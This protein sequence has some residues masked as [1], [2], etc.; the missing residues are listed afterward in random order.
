ML[1]NFLLGVVD[2]VRSTN[3]QPKVKF[4]FLAGALMAIAISLTPL[5]NAQ[6]ASAASP[7]LYVANTGSDT[8][9]NGQ[10]DNA[11]GSAPNCAFAT[12]QKAVD[13]ASPGDTIQVDAG[14]YHESPNL[15]KAVTLLGAQAG[16]TG[17][18][19]AG[20][21]TIITGTPSISVSNVTVNG[22]EFTNSGV[23]LNVSPGP[24]LHGITVRDSVFT[25][26]D[27][28][29]I[30]TYNA[31][32]IVV[33]QNLFTNPS[34]SAEPMQIKSDGGGGC[35]GTQVL[36]N[37]FNQATTNGSADVNLSCTD[38]NSTNVTVSN[39]YSLGVVNGNFA[40]FVAFSGVT[41]GITVMS[42]TA[43]SEG[44][45]V[46]FFGSVSGSALVTGNVMSHIADSAAVSI[47][48]A[49]DSGTDDTAN[50]GT[51]NITNNDFSNNDKGVSVSTGAL[52]GSAQ[53]IAN[54]NDL[55]GDTDGVGNNTGFD[56]DATQNWWGTA[57]N[58]TIASMI[59]GSGSAHVDYTPY[60]VDSS[61]TTLSNVAPANVYISGSY[62]DGHAGGHAYGYDAFQTI[63]EG[64]D[65]VATGGT[66][67][68]AA[69][70][71]NQGSSQI[72]LH[73][74]LTLAGP[75]AAISPNGGSRVAEAIIHGS[76]FGGTA[77]F[78][79]TSSSVHVAVQGFKFQDMGAAMR[80]DSPGAHITL[81]RNIFTGNMN[82]G[83]GFDDPNLTVSDNLFNSVDTPN[84]DLIQTWVGT[85]PSIGNLS[86]VN[87]H[88]HTITSDGALN[89]SD[90]GGGTVSGNTFDNVQYYG[91]LVAGNADLA[92]TGNTFNN[93]S[94]PDPGTSDTWGA[95][96]RFYNNVTPST[97]AQITGNSFTNSY[98]GISVKPAANITGA[99]IYATGNSFS[100]NGVN[101]RN[102]GTGTFDAS[103]NWWGS[104]A[105]PVGTFDGAVKFVPWCAQSACTSFLAIGEPVSLDAT[106]GVATTSSDG[107]LTMEGTSPGGTI[108]LTFPA[109]TTI[110]GTPTSPSTWDGTLNSP[111][112]TAYDVP[113]LSGYSTDTALAISV[114]SNDFTLSFDKGVRIRL[115]KQAGKR[116]GF[117]EPGG[118]FTEIS[119][120]CSGDSEAVGNALA[121]GGS[122]KIDDGSSLIV[123]TKHFTKFAS[124][125]RTLNSS[126]STSS[127]SSVAPVTFASAFGPLP[128][129]FSDTSS[130]NN[131][132]SSKVLG[133]NTQKTT[134]VISAASSAAA[135]VKAHSGKLLGLMWYW[136]LVI[137][138]TIAMLISLYRY[139]VAGLNRD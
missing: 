78:N 104:Q 119:S 90:I 105:D 121:A 61:M 118:S 107:K 54:G 94:N 36:S 76:A 12:I 92:F 114:G 2:R 128:A 1:R 110:T 81:S 97:S 113:S 47:H 85:T 74:S 50:T 122:C 28:V 136:W 25:G 52:G 19:H 100:G 79:V 134:P 124:F 18:N 7:D 13:T 57:V 99:D 55:S 115:P 108:K 38:S 10:A 70:T 21:E 75:N 5:F 112:V 72:A 111:T 101:I 4:R 26:Y 31:G 127:S 86:I 44:S 131:Q 106:G 120:T 65:A 103:P 42:N 135:A 83:M 8:I 102:H 15:N 59:S 93:I 60:Y 16:V 69:G 73:K 46:Y 91:V 24:I 88:F 48:G 23:Q 64:V 45:T 138:L 89:F 82:D 17:G 58:S 40:S 53:V 132:K 71:Y 30:T 80:S 51:F 32:N 39:N 27:S 98:L 95:G 123:W 117:I 130:S 84:S 33:E 139:K 29:G 43:S 11:T 66:V 137:A 126:G 49:G 41:G 35:T 129:A 6:M 133:E 63:Q 14:T 56:I 96:I 77:T 116:V 9:C 37:Q 125:T 109:G 67:N 87:N 68:V 22:F 3:K 34:A 62:S 20:A